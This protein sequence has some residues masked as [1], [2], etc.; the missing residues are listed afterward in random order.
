MFGIFRGFVT[1]GSGNVQETAQATVAAAPAPAPDKDEVLCPLCP[2]YCRTGPVPLKQHST[3][4]SNPE[5]PTR[6]L[7]FIK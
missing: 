3:C 6:L 1:P 4:I 7:E 2:R 5:A